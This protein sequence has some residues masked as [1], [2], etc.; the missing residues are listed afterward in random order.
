MIERAGEAA[1]ER[2][3]ARLIA[4]DDLPD[5]VTVERD[6]QGV[7]LIGRGL[8]RRRIEDVRIRGFA[9]GAGR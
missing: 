8:A 3:C 5:G 9:L 2:V 1:V 4:A 7:A 6:A